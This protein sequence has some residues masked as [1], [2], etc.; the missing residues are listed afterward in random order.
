MTRF[1]F[2]WELGS[3]Y[4]HLARL[5]PVA[6]ALRERGHGVDFVVRDLM[7]AEKLIAP[8]GMRVFQAPL[9]LRKVTHLP[10]P[11]SYPE[12][13]MRFGYIDV[14][15]L[16]GIC[17]AWRNLIGLL[18]PDVVLM[19]HA[20]TALLAT[21]G[22]PIGRINF[23][24]GFCMP[25]R[26]QPLPAFRWWLQE[27]PAR[28]VESE[29]LALSQANQVLQALGA[30]TMTSM[31]ELHACD[32]S[33][34]CTF[35]ELDH[36]PERGEQNYIG[37]IFSLD[38]GLESPWPTSGG[39]RVFAYLKP[40]YRGLEQTLNTLR[41]SRANVLAHIPGAS[42]QLI[43]GFS[44]GNMRIAAEPLRMS[45]MAFE[46]DLALC[47]GGAGTTAA[48]LLAGKPLLLLPM[49]M[50]QAMMSQRL[51]RQGMACAVTFEA[52]DQLPLLLGKVL[53]DH[54]LA[55]ATRAFAQRHRDYRQHMTIRVA[56][57]RCEAIGRARS[58]VSRYTPAQ[59]V[60]LHTAGAA[61]QA[62]PRFS[63]VICN[64]NY[65]RFVGDAVRSALNQDYPQ[66]LVQVI[67]VDDGSTDDS[68]AVC[69]QFSGD[70]RFVLVHQE[71]R[72]QTAA[73]AAGVRVATGDHVCLLDSDDVYLPHK[74]A[75]V[76][77]H[78]ASSD[79]APDEIFLCHDLNLEH[80]RQSGV[81][82]QHASWFAVT[83]IEQL[84]DRVTLAHHVT[85][86]PFSVPCGLVMARGLIKACLDAIPGWEF[87]RGAD[88]VL[89][90]AALIKTG[91]VDYLRERLGVY[92]IHGANEF[93]NIVDGQFA[94]RFKPHVREP[95]TQRFLEHWL[96]SLDKPAQERD[97]AFQYLRRKE[98]LVRRPSA[99]H[100]LVA[101]AVTVAIVGGGSG[102]DADT[103]A[104]AS[105]QSHDHIQMA[106]MPE[107]DDNELAQLARAW[108]TSDAPYI[109]FLR[110]GDRLDREF[111]ER[112]LHFRQ[113][114]ALAA[115]SCSDIRL[116]G[117]DA[118]LVHADV[119]R[120]SGAWNQALQAV[121]PMAT[122]LSDWIAPPMSACMFRRSALLDRFFAHAP[123]APTELQIAGFW[124]LFQFAHHTGGI[125]RIG[126]TLTS[127]RLPDG[128]P[129]TYGYVGNPSDLDGNLI[130]PPVAV[131][132]DWL[133]RFHRDEEAVMRQ[134]LP[135]AWHAH[136]PNWC[137]AQQAQ[138][139]P[140]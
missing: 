70:P 23:G 124:L 47:H 58:A 77:A 34:L 119:Y 10:D 128:A 1:L 60:R 78:I 79:V 22:L 106:T 131:A 127:C 38:Q 28:V 101:P 92:R 69:A 104:L 121:R 43:Q 97:L 118:S 44:G 140:G 21:R 107:T 53:D 80:T 7:G 113:H 50:E 94:P 133:A 132:L 83:G 2:V 55:Q 129:S 99:A 30:P 110:A 26:H 117:P 65:A 63:V 130:T 15:A 72:G 134:W 85:P 108:T 66:A 48:M 114:A 17:R 13:L 11:I 35:E 40:G 18:A 81:S 76:A 57:D 31:G 115:V 12:M 3:D 138:T 25:P 90:P 136:F 125:L 42:Q 61:A 82:V 84:P 49:Q 67:L 91:R 46:C 6:V 120:N 39:P 87:D 71:N 9:W 27:D 62:L 139:R 33:L 102:R 109:V 89:C 100:R 75:R 52:I 122:T 14:Q 51:A 116:V 54:T 19:D 68:L 8:L 93:A 45:Q 98:H 111:V 96:D 4:G 74:L 29:R 5:L 37:P 20:P 56:A 64:Y 126:E 41:D 73:F 112:H 135:P 137:A 88:G 36:Y 123:Q 16:T 86:F 103:S 105:L 95:K 32:D 24:D 59:P